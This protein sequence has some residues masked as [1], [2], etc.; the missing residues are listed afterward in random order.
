MEEIGDGWRVTMFVILTL[1]DMVAIEE[2]Y[3][4][5]SDGYRAKE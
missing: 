5:I 1:A 4:E 3:K 2:S